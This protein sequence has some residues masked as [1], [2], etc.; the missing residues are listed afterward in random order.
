MP[1][2]IEWKV[3]NGKNG[4]IQLVPKPRSKY[5]QCNVCKEEYEDYAEV[6]WY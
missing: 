1:V 6:F 2:T 4:L 3:W 5:S